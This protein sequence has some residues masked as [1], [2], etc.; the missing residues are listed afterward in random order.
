MRAQNKKRKTD[1]LDETERT[2][3]AEFNLIDGGVV[4]IDVAVLESDVPDTWRRGGQVEPSVTRGDVVGV[5]E[6]GV[7]VWHRVAA[8]GT[9]LTINPVVRRLNLRLTRT[10]I[11]KYAAF[12][13]SNNV[14]RHLK[15][16]F[17]WRNL[18]RNSDVTK[19]KRHL[20]KAVRIRHKIILKQFGIMQLHSSPT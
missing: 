15:A 11:W 9:I 8:V 16:P 2:Q 19:R 10:T 20:W 13:M 7:D 17:C 1:E 4:R 14:S 3:T 5:V 18:K 12:V 6:V